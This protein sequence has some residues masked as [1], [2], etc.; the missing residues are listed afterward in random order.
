MSWC[1]VEGQPSVY[2]SISVPLFVSGY[3]Q[4]MEA[5]KPSVRPYMANHLIELIGDAELYGGNPSEPSMWSGY[6]S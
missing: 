4:A 5:E 3:M 1:T 2:D 6:N